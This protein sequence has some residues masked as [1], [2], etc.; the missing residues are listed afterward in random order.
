[1]E[2]GI[3]ERRGGKEKEE[4]VLQILAMVLFQIVE[5]WCLGVEREY[6]GKNAHDFLSLAHYSDS[7]QTDDSI[8]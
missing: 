8:K 5:R 4:D 7:I 6:F 2:N 1:M 3:K